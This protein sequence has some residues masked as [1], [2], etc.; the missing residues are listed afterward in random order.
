MKKTFFMFLTIVGMA[1]TV[2][3]VCSLV[4]G[5]AHNAMLVLVIAAISY[6]VTPLFLALGVLDEKIGMDDYT[7]CLIGL[8]LIWI[9]ALILIGVIVLISSL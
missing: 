8:S 1:V 5:V 4:F 3:S 7:A 9:V 2:A 6:F